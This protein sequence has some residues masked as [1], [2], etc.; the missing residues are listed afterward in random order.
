MA[1]SDYNIGRIKSDLKYKTIFNGSITYNG[2]PCWIYIGSPDTIGRGRIQINH[3]KYLVSR[4]SAHIYLGLDIDNDK[5][6]A[7]HHCDNPRCWNPDHL[8]IGNNHDNSVDMVS[9]RRDRNSR[10][11]HCIRGHNYDGVDNRGKRYCL[12]CDRERRKTV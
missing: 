1:L 10:K 12:T 9:K 2:T 5:I 6:L 3:K 8:F 4:L 7:C 11:T